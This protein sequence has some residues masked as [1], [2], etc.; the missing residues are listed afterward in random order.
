M[1]VLV[2]ALGI[3]IVKFL[4]TV[5]VFVSSFKRLNPMAAILMAYD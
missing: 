3:L 2:N 1:N 5:I 4:L